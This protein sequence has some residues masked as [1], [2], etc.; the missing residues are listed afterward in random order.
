MMMAAALHDSSSH[1]SNGR[2][3]H[4]F[5]DVRGRLRKISGMSTVDDADAHAHAHAHGH[6]AG[7]S[8]QAAVP[9]ESKPT[10]HSHFG[11]LEDAHIT[12]AQAWTRRNMNM[13][14]T[15]SNQPQS[16]LFTRLPL[17]IRRIIY[18][19]IWR[20]HLG[21]DTRIH[22]YAA[23]RAAGLT[24]APCVCVGA[25]DNL[26][27]TPD[28]DDPIN[29]NPWPAWRGAKQPPE[30]FWHAWS[31]RLRWG[32]HWRCQENVML[33][34]G[35]SGG[36]ADQGVCSDN[37]PGRGGEKTPYLNVFLTCKF[38]SVLLSHIEPPF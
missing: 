37:R 5:L 38:M 31:L 12:S 8:L 4:A 11:S 18:A 9:T 6:G 24:H 29:S 10:E 26:E 2:R 28:D 16:P 27:T 22:I 36:D 15:A 21:P 35:S 19:D 32:R 1:N 17:E 25:D 13:E 30:W 7:Q 33:Q 3:R 20:A 14:D 34:W 23:P